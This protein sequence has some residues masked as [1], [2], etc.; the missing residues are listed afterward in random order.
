MNSQSYVNMIV[1]QN[2]TFHSAFKPAQKAKNVTFLGYDAETKFKM[3]TLK[4]QTEQQ[5]RDL[6]EALDREIQ[7]KEETE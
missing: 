7:A 2:F 3:Y 4:T 1:L 5:A 6:K